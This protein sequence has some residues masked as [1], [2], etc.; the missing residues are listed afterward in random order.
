M[1]DSGLVSNNAS[2]VTSLIMFQNN[3]KQ[4]KYFTLQTKKKGILEKQPFY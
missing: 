3:V 4:F 1:S 2:C